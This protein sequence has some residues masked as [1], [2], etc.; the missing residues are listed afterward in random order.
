MSCFEDIARKSNYAVI[1]VTLQNYYE[2]RKR[3]GEARINSH[4][5]RHY[6]A[7]RT[8]Y[9]CLIRN[10]RLVV[11][12]RW[13]KVRASSGA[14]NQEVRKLTMVMTVLCLASIAFN[15][16]FFVALCMEQRSNPN[17]QLPER[18]ENGLEAGCPQLPL[19]NTNRF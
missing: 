11:S 3:R 17:K 8:F 7:L 6:R 14:P 15:I 2:Y 1:V 16:R 19:D 5:Q 10:L 9:E 13:S 18:S 12:N 4:K